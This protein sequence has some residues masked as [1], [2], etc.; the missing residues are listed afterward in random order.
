MA[1]LRIAGSIWAG[2]ER[3]LILRDAIVTLGR[4]K[5]NNVVLDGN[6]VSRHHAR[7]LQ[8]PDG[9]V[10][11]D[12]G[13]ANGTYVN[14]VRIARHVLLEGHVIGLGSVRMT[15]F[16]GLAPPPGPPPLPTLPSLTKPPPL[17]APGPPPLPPI[18]PSPPGRGPG[19][20]WVFGGLGLLLLV[21]LL[22]L[23]LLWP[24]L[25][26]RLAPPAAAPGPVAGAVVPAGLV[27]LPRST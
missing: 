8:V 1:I 20:A 19:L 15:F 23:L 27:G 13:S 24:R 26:E 6:Q 7:L 12:L 2:P 25:K 14:G 22:A 17:P 9:W 18:R 11:E 16:G 5:D 10:L 4:E 3:D 21:G